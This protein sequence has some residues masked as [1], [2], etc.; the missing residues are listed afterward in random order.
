M[1]GRSLVV[2]GTLQEGRAFLPKVDPAGWENE[3]QL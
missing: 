2:E 3:M 1:D